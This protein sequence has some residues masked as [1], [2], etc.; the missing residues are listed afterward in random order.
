[1]HQWSTYARA[2]PPWHVRQTFD[3][4][5]EHWIDGQLAGDQYLKGLTVDSDDPYHIDGLVLAAD[6]GAA[7]IITATTSSERDASIDRAGG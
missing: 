5:L 3:V 6:D 4:Y 2:G 1:M 7:T